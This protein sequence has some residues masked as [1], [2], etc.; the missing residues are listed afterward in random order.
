MQTL[1][2]LIAAAMLCVGPAAAHAIEGSS[3]AGPIG[4]TDMRVAL[5]PPPGLYGGIVFVGSQLYHFVDGTGARVPAIA[6][7]RVSSVVGG[8]AA[9]YVPDAKVLGG[10]LAFLGTVAAGEKC[11]HLF[12]GT[13]KLCRFGFGDPYFEIAWGRQFGHMRPSKY[14]GAFPIFEGFAVTLGF[15]IV[16]PIGQYN[17]FEA[18]N[19]AGS[20]G[21]NVWDFA[22]N[23]AVTYTTPAIIAEG[24][25]FSAKF[26]WNN[27]LENPATRYLTGTLLNVDFAITEHIGRF[28]VG[29]TGFY[30][31][32]VADDT[33]SGMPLPPD[34]RQI[35]LL[36]LGGI[37]SYD[38]PE[39][40]ATLKVKALTTAVSANTGSSQAVVVALAK[41]LY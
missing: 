9:L 13:G 5:L 41:K 31:T 1:R 15:G 28:Q 12:V 16:A 26:Y 11:G 23:I 8:V 32:Q 22:P 37:I 20:H 18:Q 6:D 35:D 40:G 38:M 14:P 34:G 33:L 4:G 25:E 10:S 29:F 24:T 3:A 21:N 30:V 17:A 7:A 19:F 39:Y 2:T 27:Y 36:Y